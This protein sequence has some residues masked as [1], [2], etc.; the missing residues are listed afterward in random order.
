MM[1][2]RKRLDSPIGTLLLEG[3]EKG[4]SAIRLLSQEEQAQ[5]EQTQPEQTNAVLEQ[6]AA[7]LDAY[8]AGERKAF[9]FPL[10]LH[11]TAFES[12][13]WRA[14][15]QIPYG[16]TRSYGQLAAQLHMPGGARAVGGA[17]RRNPLL[18]AV[19]CHRVIAAS[20]NLTGFAAGLEAKKR[21]LLL[22]G[23]RLDC[24]KRVL[25]K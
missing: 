11:G 21:L 9:D 3:D 8:F 18:I 24:G 2:R 23:H 13:V 22:E 4:V 7:Q 19:P 25:C 17:C 16:Q 6:A 14:L 20:G 12:A 15:L 5:P 1:K 10:V